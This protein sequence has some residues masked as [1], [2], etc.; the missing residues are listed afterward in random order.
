VVLY[1]LLT[2]RLPY[3]RP[4][5]SIAATA[6]AIALGEVAPP[7]RFDRRCRGDLDAIV[8]KAMSLDPA[9]R[10]DSASALAADLRSHLD[11]LPIQ[12][13][14][15]GRVRRFRKFLVRHRLAATAILAVFLALS[16]GLA[17]SLQAK[18]KAERALY[19]SLLAQGSLMASRTD[20]GSALNV[21]ES[22][23]PAWQE[24]WPV[25]VIER[26]TN[27]TIDSADF[28]TWRLFRGRLSHD[29]DRLL[30]YG[31]GERPELLVLET[32]P[33]RVVRRI[34]LPSTG[35][36]ADW[37]FTL[38]DGTESV[39][40]G[41]V[42]GRVVEVLATDGSIVREITRMVHTGHMGNT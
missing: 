36:G 27:P 19:L 9:D 2:G 28:A 39:I 7:S 22:L 37:G 24:E 6:T 16:T 33:A 17:S 8:A 26:F 40:A 12:A 35:M 34:P 1:E 29:R 30:A 21:L 31:C 42:D 23:D 13:R 4:S 18:A 41:L 15:V 3:G 10:Y 32:S 38:P 20:L 11:D 5:G 25:R 14:G